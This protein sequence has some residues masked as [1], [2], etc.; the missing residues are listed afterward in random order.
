MTTTPTSL[1]SKPSHAVH[2]VADRL[3]LSERT[4]RRLIASGRIGV[5]RIM[6]TVRIPEVELERFLQEQFIPPSV[7]PRKNVPQA[8]ARIVAAVRWAGRNRKGGS[9]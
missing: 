4:V 9:R 5:L 8:A 3:G 2:V 7:N 6:G 1:A